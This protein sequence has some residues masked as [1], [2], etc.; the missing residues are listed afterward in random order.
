MELEINVPELKHCRYESEQKNNNARNTLQQTN[1]PR[2]PA[3]TKMMVLPLTQRKPRKPR[4]S[5]SQCQSKTNTTIRIHTK[6]HIHKK[7]LVFNRQTKICLP[8]CM[9]KS[10]LL[11]YV[12]FVTN[13]NNTSTRHIK[14][15]Q[16]V[17]RLQIWTTIKKMHEKL[18]RLA[19]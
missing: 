18:K 15:V 4:Q 17:S 5:Q 10:I 6:A 11:A 1:P 16:C 2:Q 12:S 8:F 7:D 3:N 19:L 9:G 14:T 13:E